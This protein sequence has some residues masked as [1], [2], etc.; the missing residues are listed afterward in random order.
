MFGMAGS[1]EYLYAVQTAESM[2]KTLKQDIA[3]LTN[4]RVVPLI[5][6]QE[7]P[8]EIVRSPEKVGEAEWI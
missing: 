3:I 4:F 1:C 6:N 2:A 7:M 5:N 8:L